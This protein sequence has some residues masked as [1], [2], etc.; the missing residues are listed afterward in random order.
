MLLRKS[1]AAVLIFSVTAATASAEP[2]SSQQTPEIGSGNTVFACDLY[3]GL[4]QGEGNL[5]FSPFSVS[6]ALAM[7]AAGARGSTKAQMHHALHLTMG[8]AG[9][10]AVR[11]GRR[12]A[13]L[14]HFGE[15][16][17][18]G[19]V[20]LDMANA[21]WPQQGFPIRDDF[22]SQSRQD[23]GVEITALDYRN[24]SEAQRRSNRWV[25]DRTRDWIQSLTSRSASSSHPP[26]AGERSLFPWRLG[27]QLQA[28]GNPRWRVL[29]GTESGDAQILELPYKGAALS[30][31]VALP[32]DKT[33]AGLARLEKTPGGPAITAFRAE[34]RP[35]RVAVVLPRFRIA[36]GTTSLLPDSHGSRHPRRL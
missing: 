10:A 22:Q 25:D 33:P 7:T 1:A 18:T 8:S 26:R 23:F 32:R 34:L 11:A 16:N 2:P 19:H 35:T 12:A 13:L 9:V 30:M 29:F 4:R 21:L 5:F 20:E 15:V 31:I 27:P 28:P 24:G 36:W 3:A 14:R 17:Q 6:T